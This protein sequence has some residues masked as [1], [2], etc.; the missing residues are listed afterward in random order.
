MA[1]P[2]IF[3]FMFEIAS[4]FSSLR[5]L[6]PR[7]KP[8]VVLCHRG[9]FSEQRM[10]L[11]RAFGDRFLECEGS[12]THTMAQ[13]L[14]F[15]GAGKLPLVLFKAGDF[16]S[17]LLDLLR[18]SPLPPNLKMVMVG[19]SQPIKGIDFSVFASEEG[20]DD[21]VNYFGPQLIKIF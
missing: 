11:V 7:H 18:L 2:T 14:G 19:D 5:A 10:D 6:A 21:L 8:L 1:I 9:V 17:S 12:L 3:Y 20:L 15:S 4:F 16:E 13:A